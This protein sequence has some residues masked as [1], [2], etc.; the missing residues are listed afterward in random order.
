MD[1]ALD[2]LASAAT[3]E[4]AIL[5]QLIATNSSLATSNTTLTNQVK[6]LHDQLAAKT[7]GGGRRGGGS[8]DPNRGKGPNLAGYC[9]SHGY[10][11]GH[12]H[13]GH[14]CSNPMGGPPA[15]H[16]LCQHHRQIHGKQ[17]LD[18]KQDHLRPRARHDSSN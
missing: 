9:W 13:T 16:H 4:K 3:N 8:N 10:H 2:N 12:G 6:A 14:T 7:K 17:G 18:A 5:E 15:Y 1:N 11:I